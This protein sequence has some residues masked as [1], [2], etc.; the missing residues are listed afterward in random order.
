MKKIECFAGDDGDSLYV[1]ERS[2]S[3]FEE[4]EKNP[5]PEEPTPMDVKVSLSL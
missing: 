2:K 5:H 4:D 1:E 3:H